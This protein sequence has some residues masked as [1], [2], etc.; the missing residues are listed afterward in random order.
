MRTIS[1]KIMS[2]LYL[3]IFNVHAS[4]EIDF[5][6]R[7][8]T[9]EQWL[10]HMENGLSP[11]WM[12]P[13]AYGE[14]VGNFPTF[15]CDDGQVL[16]LSNPCPELANQRWIAQEFGRDFTRM[17]SRQ[18]YAYGV[19]YHL[20]GDPKA[21]SLAKAGVD[22]L[23]TQ[24][25]DTK[26]GGMIS[27]REGQQAKFKWQQRTSQDQAYAIVGLAFYYYLTRDPEV[28]KALVEQQHFIFEHYKSTTKNQL[29]WV[30][31]DS[32]EHFHQQLE[33]VAQLDQINAYLLL[34]TPLLPKQHQLKWRADLEWLTE[35]MLAQY[36][37][38][39]QWRFYGAIHHRAV[40]RETAKHNDFGH[41]IKAYWM[42]Y[43]VGQQL[44][45]DDWVDLALK[46]MKSTIAKA[47]YQ[48]S[49]SYLK[50]ILSTDQLA[51]IEY[52]H[53]YSWRESN[54]SDWISSW[55]WAELDQA[56]M[57]LSIREGNNLSPQLVRQLYFTTTSFQQFWVDESYGGVGLMPKTLKQFH[58]GNAY[59][60]FE[61]ALVGYLS[62]QAWYDKPATLYYALPPLADVTLQPYYFSGEVLS[63]QITSIALDIP[64]LEQV[65]VSFRITPGN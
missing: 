5:A 34:V 43:L 13:S 49:K 39:E 64:M 48:Y 65:E 11:Y 7:I 27:V 8:A 12:A 47:A 59:H 60:Q 26:N 21:L 18:I 29:L 63:H 40:M 61:H 46:G 55:Q 51:A 1:A 36:H 30:I 25:R 24:L 20:T 37:N 58:W 53:L 2:C 4:T 62:A 33:L 9:G 41:T 52:S 54:Y 32:H 28:E 23:L 16:E 44:N 22:Y 14:P 6:K 19:R 17:K 15:R 31:E 10:S 38:V 42:T 56:L 3:I 35:Q 57:T 50:D 45:R